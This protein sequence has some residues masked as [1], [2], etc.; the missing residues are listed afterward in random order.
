MAEPAGLRGGRL[1]DVGGGL[2]QQG[3]IDGQ[4]QSLA[5]LAI[6]AVGGGPLAEVDDVLA[7]G[8]AVE[9]LEQEEVDG[10]GRAEAAF[11]Q[12]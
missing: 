10:D 2:L 8:V 12:E 5:G 11:R 9:D 6:G 7:G 3:V 1:T 4:W